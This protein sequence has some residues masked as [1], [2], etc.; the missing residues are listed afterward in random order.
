[1]AVA[2]PHEVKMCMGAHDIFG[3]QRTMTDKQRKILEL[4]KDGPMRTHEIVRALYG[5][6]SLVNKR[7]GPNV[8][9]C[10]QALQKDGLVVAR[11]AEGCSR[12]LVY[13][14]AAFEE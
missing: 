13:S 2:A 8:S 7:F 14:L 12:S 10:M 6:G 11:V 9:K 3:R 4:L 1:M 5:D